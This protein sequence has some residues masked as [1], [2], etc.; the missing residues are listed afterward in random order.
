M[1]LF[2]CSLESLLLSQVDLPG[3]ENVITRQFLGSGDHFLSTDDADVVRGL[4]VF[5]SSIGVSEHRQK[6]DETTTHVTTSVVII[7]MI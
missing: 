5:R 3:V 1:F 7:R 6:G 2:V 4:Q